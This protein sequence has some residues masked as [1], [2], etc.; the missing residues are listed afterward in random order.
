MGRSKSMLG[1]AVL[2]LAVGVPLALQGWAGLQG[3]MTFL[4]QQSARLAG[5]LLIVLSITVL[6]RQARR[7]PAAPKQATAVPRESGAG[8]QPAGTAPRP[9]PPTA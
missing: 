7:W 3:L 1:A 2:G 6:I 8:E 4:E 9:E 5:G